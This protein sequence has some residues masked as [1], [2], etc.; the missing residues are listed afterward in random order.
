MR[1]ILTVV[2]LIAGLAAC[3]SPTGPSTML[4]GSVRAERGLTQP[5]PMGVN[6][7]WSDLNP[8]PLP[9]GLHLATSGLNPQPLPPGRHGATAT[10]LA[11]TTSGTLRTSITLY[12]PPDPCLK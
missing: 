8:Q 6:A 7:A 10:T 3:E 12:Q 1:A 2:A 4:D 5:L 11:C 9:P